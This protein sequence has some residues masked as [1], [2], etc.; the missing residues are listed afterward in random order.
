MAQAKEQGLTHLPRDQIEAF[1]EVY[2]E[3]VG[4]QATPG[5][6][7][8]QPAARQT[9]PATNL[10][11]RLRDF[12]DAIWRFVTD[13]RVPFINNLAERMVRPIRVKL[14]VIGGFR[15][16]GGSFASFIIRSVWESSKLRGQN[17][18]EVLRLAATA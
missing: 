7:G 1:L 18:F 17:S 9:A 6:R 5:P 12:P 3:Q 4:R 15:G 11:L 2:D 14:K 10:L 13:W 8:Q 16:K